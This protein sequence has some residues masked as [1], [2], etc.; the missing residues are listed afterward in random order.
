[1]LVTISE[2]AAFLGVTEKEVKEE[3]LK[4]RLAITCLTSRTR[5]VVVKSLLDYERRRRRG[6]FRPR[7][8]EPLRG[9]IYFIQAGKAGPIKI[10]YSDKVA[11]RLRDLQTSSPAELRLLNVRPGNYQLEH[12]LQIRLKR[13][14]IRNEWFRPVEAVLQEVYGS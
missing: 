10:G 7:L 12:A 13:Y 5:R 8:A 14:C 4:G 2:A 3:A 6:E 9:G 1:V 11:N